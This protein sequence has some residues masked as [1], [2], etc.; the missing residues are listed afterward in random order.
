METQKRKLE[1]LSPSI[2]DY[3]VQPRNYQLNFPEKTYY[4]IKFGEFISDRNISIQEGKN[5]LKILTNSEGKCWA[6]VDY[7]S[8]E[9]KSYP[10]NKQY[11][12]IFRSMPTHFQ[13][14]FF[15]F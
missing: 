13:I 12:Y 6:I 7:I 15:Q 1:T 4:N 8:T 9:K 5:E 2:P 14:R 10:E 3:I 11:E